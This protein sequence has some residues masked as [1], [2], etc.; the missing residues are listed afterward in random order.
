MT[1]AA[2][3]RPR[4]GLGR[5]FHSRP[6]GVPT[7]EERERRA[8]LGLDDGSA[9]SGAAALGAAY[10]TRWCDG[11][12]RCGAP[13]VGGVSVDRPPPSAL[14]ARWVVDLRPQE[15]FDA[16]HFALTRHLPP[17]EL[18]RSGA[19]AAA[20]DELLALCCEGGAA[21]GL[22]KVPCLRGRRTPP[23]LPPWTI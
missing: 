6:P 20:R 15:E 1:P 11:T 7:P 18:A 23:P 22:Q 10:H 9:R 17:L 5:I 19:R 4:Q 21:A 16:A 12:P 3:A 13:P 8:Q 14:A 2:R